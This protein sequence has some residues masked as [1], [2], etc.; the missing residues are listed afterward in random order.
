MAARGVQT[1]GSPDERN[2]FRRSDNRATDL[3]AR[4]TRSHVL[5][6]AWPIVLAQAATATTGVVN[7]V[8]MGRFGSAV[9]LAAVSIAAVSISFI[10]WGFGFL[11]MSTTGLTAQAEGAGDHVE[12]RAVLLRAA[13]IGLAL[14]VGLIVLFPLIRA[15]ALGAFQAEATV[16]LHATGYL[17]A[18]IWGA[19]AALIGFA[20]NG[21][22]IGTGRTRAL[23]V[24]QIV[25]NGV[26]A[27][28]D[29]WFVAGLNLG[30]A[31]IGAGT[32]IAEWAAL[33]VG[34]WMVRSQLKPVAHLFERTR[35]V[36]LLAANR[37]LMI[38]TLALLFSFA[39]FINSGARAGT[40]ELAGNEVLLQ[41][42]T[43]AAFVLDA[44][45]FVAEKEVG[46]AF[47]ARDPAR[48]RRAVRLTTEFA[49]GFGLAF[50]ALYLIGGRVIIEGVVADPAARAAALAFL[51]FCAVVPLIGMPAWQLDGI[52]IGT[53][54]GR[55]LRTAGFAAAVLY[56]ATDLILAPRFGN[57]GVWT[58]FLLMYVFRALC[59]GAFWPGLVR[60]TAGP[61][62]R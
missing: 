62:D 18:R 16:E 46:Q 23:L 35:M 54:R 47:G 45:A 4:L 55:A 43:V 11:R 33:G 6:L 51:P 40:A 38:R 28:L 48:L 42:I 22:L 44:F 53:T 37:D 13:V 20:I 32:A 61:R 21:W 26:N 39:W 59:L 50:S 14:G 36:A 49:L 60:D 5:A 10:Y 29:T 58:A 12:S 8:V 30:P 25:L 7:T 27:V 41:F 56:V 17:N 3:T 57:T 9:D 1:V 52:F 2:R 34:L 24:L 31:G 15:V 19:P